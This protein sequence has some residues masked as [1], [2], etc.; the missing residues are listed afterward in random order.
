MMRTARKATPARRRRNGV[1]VHVD[2]GSHNA[3]DS[4]GAKT[5]PAPTRHAYAARPGR[6]R[7]LDDLRNELESVWKPRQYASDWLVRMEGRKRGEALLER[8]KRKA[9][10]M[11]KAGQITAAELEHY[12]RNPRRSSARRTKSAAPS[13]RAMRARYGARALSVAFA[14]KN[15]A[16]TPAQRRHWSRVVE[17]L[18][19]KRERG[20]R[21][22]NPAPA[23]FPVRVIQA[24]GEVAAFRSL[25][26][27]RQY[28]QA[29]ANRTGRPVKV[30]A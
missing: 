27:A 5:N 17:T 19:G 8:I 6:E 16:R 4:R 25:P 29:L 30:R 15:L 7:S 18:E 1:E 20:E 14:M 28:A 26:R 9:R 24:G 2:V 11:H 21:S 3:R 12:T 22:R 10:R 23:A 13:A